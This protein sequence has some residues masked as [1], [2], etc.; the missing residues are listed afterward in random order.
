MVADPAALPLSVAHKDAE[1]VAAAARE[2]GL[3]LAIGEALR[4]SLADRRSCRGCS[5][6]VRRP[7]EKGR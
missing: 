7:D 3:E 1:L 2:A 5:T 4:R 6:G